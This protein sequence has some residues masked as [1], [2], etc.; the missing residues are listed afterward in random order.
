MES[1]EQIN[2]IKSSRQIVYNTLTT[3]EGLANV[4]T[5]KLK[6]KPMV[7]F[8][9]E[10]DFDEGYINKMKVSEL[11]ENSSIVWDCIDSDEEWVGTS[12]S[13][14]LSE[15]DGVTTVS[16]SHAGWRARTE[17]YGWCS[18]NWAMFLFRL[19]KYCE[20]ISHT[21]LEK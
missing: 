13:F 19:K 15:K 8:I 20:N 18:Y 12:I 9:N 10:F 11:V 7:G 2:Y 6:V 21:G 17:Y 3:E 16:L 4:W 1:I 5:K 14:H